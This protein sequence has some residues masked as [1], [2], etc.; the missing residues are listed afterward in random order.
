MDGP[1]DARK[2]M[3]NDHDRPMSCRRT[4]SLITALRA[5]LLEAAPGMSDDDPR[6]QDL[7]KIAE[8]L[9]HRGLDGDS[10]IRYGL[11]P[12]LVAGVMAHTLPHWIPSLRV[13]RHPAP[14]ELPDASPLPSAPDTE[15]TW[16]R[17]LDPLLRDELSPPE[18]MEPS[19]AALTG[20]L[21]WLV[22]KLDPWILTASADDLLTLR[23]PS[24]ERLT[25]NSQC[26][27]DVETLVDYRW[28]IDRFAITHLHDWST[29]SLHREY[30][31]RQGT[32]PPPCVEALMSDRMVSDR[33]LN[34]EIAHRAVV[35]DAPKDVIGP[36]LSLALLARLHSRARECLRADQPREAAALYEFAVG[37]SP[38]DAD[39]V[40]NLGFCLV[41]QDPRRALARLE[42]ANRLGYPNTEVNLHNRALCKL[43]LGEH[44]SVL[45][46]I[47]GFWDQAQGEPALL[48]RPDPRGLRLLVDAN[49][50]TEL[51]YLA[52]H[53]ATFLDDEDA[54]DHWSRLSRIENDE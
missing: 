33:H 36:G 41:P 23:P 27:P 14:I 35:A 54:C 10:L 26:R 22:E 8:E 6:V 19:P 43:L 38:H 37:E 30:G 40:N 1:F 16:V 49:T 29:S 52:V 20:L 18:P 9:T 17:L 48:W 47:R 44:A 7:R 31:W 34:D 2:V 51:A 4:V 32:R 45:A 12:E 25:A 13:A 3:L 46:M 24:P 5:A 50:R 42:E 21:N 15:E 28:I 39:L 53:A 11:G